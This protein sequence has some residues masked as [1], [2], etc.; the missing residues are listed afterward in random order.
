MKILLDRIQ[1]K[2]MS[3]LQT[4]FICNLYPFFR[5]LKKFACQYKLWNFERQNYGP[6]KWREIK[7]SVMFFENEGKIAN[8]CLHFQCFFFTISWA[9]NVEK[10]FNVPWGIM[11]HSWTSMFD[12][13]SLMHGETFSKYSFE[14]KTSV[15]AVQFFNVS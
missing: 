9:N 2:I 10:S 1:G 14:A 8:F 3:S 12:I 7:K 13:K 11:H 5:S 6:E 15:L 4:D